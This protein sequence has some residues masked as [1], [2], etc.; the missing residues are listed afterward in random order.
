MLDAVWKYFLTYQQLNN[1]RHLGH[2]WLPEDV[3]L[4]HKRLASY[5]QDAYLGG[6]AQPRG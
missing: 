4:E 3:I 1:G 2:R 5:Y 6:P